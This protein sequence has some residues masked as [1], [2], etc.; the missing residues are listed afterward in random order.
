VL[1]GRKIVIFVCVYVD[2]QRTVLE[3]GY[4]GISACHAWYHAR[5]FYMHICGL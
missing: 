5:S 4:P 3:L 2:W 1:K